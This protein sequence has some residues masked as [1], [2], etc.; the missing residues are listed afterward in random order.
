MNSTARGCGN[1]TT[2]LP[3][4]INLLRT[5]RISFYRDAFEAARARDGY[6]FYGA[7]LRVELAKGNQ[8]P[9]FGGG[10]GGFG[11]G[12]G[13]SGGYGGPPPPFG[14][15]SGSSSRNLAPESACCVLV[16][17]LHCSCFSAG[18]PEPR[19]QSRGRQIV[20]DARPLKGQPTGQ[21][22]ASENAVVA[23]RLWCRPLAHGRCPKLC[24]RPVDTG[25]NVGMARLPHLLGASCAN[26]GA[27]ILLDSL[28]QV[29][30]AV[31]RK[32]G[33]GDAVLAHRNAPSK[34][35]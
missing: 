33:R 32:V 5:W 3:C 18:F 6:D 16:C 22:K 19:R 20:L 30:R 21:H 24:A 35:T 27:V 14:G 23:A 26:A 11:G 13:G 12:Y 15:G 34:T 10:G 25:A 31:V 7:R 2:V 4:L 17:L 8:P 1:I 29:Q 9:P 28:L